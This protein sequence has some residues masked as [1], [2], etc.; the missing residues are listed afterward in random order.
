MDDVGKAIV[1]I[2]QVLLFA[3]ACTVSIVLYSAITNSID[4]VMLSKDFSNQGDSITGTDEEQKEREAAAAEVILAILDLKEKPSGDSVIVD[5]KTYTYDSSNQ[6]I[7][8]SGGVDWD[9]GSENL[10]NDLTSQIS[11]TYKII[12]YNENFLEYKTY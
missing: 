11:G 7:K 9:Y 8:R 4:S 10:Y 2:S 5:G 12:D 1:M 3:L 6:K